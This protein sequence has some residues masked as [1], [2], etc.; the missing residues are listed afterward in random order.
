MTQAQVG[1]LSFS[2]LVKEAKR[3][4]GI[5][6]NTNVSDGGLTG[7]NNPLQQEE[8][9]QKHSRKIIKHTKIAPT[10]QKVIVESNLK[11]EIIN[12]IRSEFKRLRINPLDKEEETVYIPSDG[13]QVE[14]HIEP[15]LSTEDN[16]ITNAVDKLKRLK[17]K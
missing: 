14:T 10:N 7:A 6:N 9:L 8:V 17:E 1:E 12:V 13:P 2:Q 3:L 11:E 5:C 4:D 15:E 16:T